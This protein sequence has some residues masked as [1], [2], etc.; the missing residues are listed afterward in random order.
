MT[1]F[2]SLV[3]GAVLVIFLISSP[4]PSSLLLRVLECV[5]MAWLVLHRFASSRFRAH[6]LFSLS[7][8]LWGHSDAWV[9]MYTSILALVVGLWYG[10]VQVDPAYA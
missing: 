1:F 8:A 2:G 6:H 3:L 9:L 5:S 7:I 4:S 10:V